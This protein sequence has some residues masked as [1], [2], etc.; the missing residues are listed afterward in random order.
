MPFYIFEN[1]E[2]KERREVRQR[3]SDTHQYTD[4]NGLKWNRV[5]LAGNM[6]VDSRPNVECTKS[7][8]NSTSNK[9]ETVGDIQDRAKEASEKRKEKN[10]YDPIQSN[11][12]NSY[13]EKRGGKRHPKDPS[14]GGDVFEV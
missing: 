11:W 13:A 7:L 2:T 6:S 12:F 9:K 4:E 8:A 14:G 3:M 10:G 5:F 1:P